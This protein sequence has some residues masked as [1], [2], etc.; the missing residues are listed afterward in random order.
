VSATRPAV[1][2]VVPVHDRTEW[3]SAA[4]RSIR[5]QRDVG[6]I[7]TVV[8]DDGSREPVEPRFR[9]EFPEVRWVR[10]ENRGV[11]A[12]RQTGALQARGDVVA[13]LDDDDVWHPDKTRLQMA[14]LRARPE[15]GVVGCDV[16]A[17]ASLS[18]EGDDGLLR[19]RGVVAA[20]ASGP[21]AGLPRAH[22]LSGPRLIRFAFEH[23]P[24]FPQTLLVARAALRASGGWNP[25]VRSF[26]DCHDFVARAAHS[27]VVGFLDAPLVGLRRGHGEHMTRDEGRAYF[28]QARALVRLYGLYPAALRAELDAPLA[29]LLDRTFHRLVSRGRPRAAAT[30]LVALMHHDGVTARRLLQLGRCVLAA[31]AAAGRRPT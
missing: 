10:Q 17:P 21:V 22:L 15:V 20:T 7:E 23:F 31:S 13:F 27:C 18:A 19:S 9:R 11:S 26:G 2:A 16:A 24:L 3:L 25:R 29:H 12:A 28:E 14:L 5:E 1:S 30:T 6:E 8:V 4:L